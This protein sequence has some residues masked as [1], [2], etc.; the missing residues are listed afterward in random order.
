ME[1][2]RESVDPFNV[3][4]RKSGFRHGPARTSRTEI[5]RLNLETQTWTRATILG[6]GLISIVCVVSF[7]SG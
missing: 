7:G 6:Q 2:L 1:N 4:P 5:R 3:N